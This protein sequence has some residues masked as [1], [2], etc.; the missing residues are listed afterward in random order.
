MPYNY[1]HMLEQLPP[2][3]PEDVLPGLQREVR[4]AGS[5]IVVLDDDPTGTQTVY[6]VPILTRWSEDILK[7]EL[8]TAPPLFYIL[9]N[10]RSLTESDAAELARTIGSNLNR[11][12]VETGRAVTVI[13]RSDSTL[14]GHYPAEVDTLAGAL[15]MSDA[16][17]VVIPFFGEGGRLTIEDVH[18]VREGD[19]L[20]PAHETPF[21]A[22]AVFGYSTANLKDWIAEKTGGRIPAEFVRSVSLAD[23]RQ[24]GP[25]R[26]RDVVMACRPGEACVI[27]AV[28]YRDM[29]VAAYGLL[30]AEQAE[31]PLIYR[32]AASFVRVRAGLKARPLL[33]AEDLQLTATGGGL[34]VVGSYVEKSTV[35]LTHMLK[36]TK[37]VPVEISVAD[38]LND[39]ARQ[40]TIQQTIT[41]IDDALQ[42]Q[43]TA[44]LYTSRTLLTVDAAA[45]NLAIGQSVSAALVAVVRGIQSIPRYVLA[46]GGIT[47]S[48]LATR[49]YSATRAQVLGQI[50]PGVP[51]W[52][53]VA[54][55]RVPNMAYIVFP[56]NVGE[57]D[58][59]TQ[60]VAMLQP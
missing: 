41:R 46:K 7:A 5:T 58:A 33:Q 14:R 19:D 1:Q 43:K 36:N 25:E 15:G 20:K 29:E 30:Q 22:D 28:T 34:V 16:V 42:Q 59:L 52:R 56:G 21:A 50:L 35:Q 31:K 37:C 54:N 24:G 47:S 32:T 23:I 8:Q 44:V 6:D 3:W 38:L 40:Q 45:G 53:F 4:S 60:I 2:E 48:D 57:A 9:T 17:H 11:A 39:D 26:V 10:S 27:N 12:A 18:Y 51:V 55:S 49:A 13:S